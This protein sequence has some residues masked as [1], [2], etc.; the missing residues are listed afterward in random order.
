MTFTLEDVS[1]KEDLDLNIS[2]DNKLLQDVFL[3][4]KDFF[5]T[6]GYPNEYEKPPS[7]FGPAR[8]N[9][10]FGGE[11]K[12]KLKPYS[13]GYERKIQSLLKDIKGSKDLL[14]M[15]VS[16]I[17]KLE[18]EK[19]QH[20]AYQQEQ[21][22][23]ITELKEVIELQD[24]YYDDAI[25]QHDEDAILKIE[26]KISEAKKGIRFSTIR[27]KAETEAISIIDK[28]L[29]CLTQIRSVI[30]KRYNEVLLTIAEKKFREK[31]D[32]FL[33]D[34]A[35]YWAQ[36]KKTGFYAFNVP[37]LEKKNLMT[38]VWDSMKERIR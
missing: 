23:L 19:N 6:E 21:A 11:S 25:R 4:L 27:D 16:H 15:I 14:D 32:L 5:E 37:Q 12:S 9:F 3:Q 28:N 18:A 31:L 22:D 1:T 26:S 17:A 36:R 38:I 33:D 20:K 8:I 34:V 2:L 7:S 10:C 35:E 13:W 24:T 30:S 29:M